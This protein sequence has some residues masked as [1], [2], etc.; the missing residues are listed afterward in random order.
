M[1]PESYEKIVADF[2]RKD[3]N[4]SILQAYYKGQKHLYASQICV[5]NIS[6]DLGPKEFGLEKEVK[7][8]M[9]VAH[10]KGTV[11][12]PVGGTYHFVGIADDLMFVRFD[13]KTVHNSSLRFHSG[14]DKDL[15]H[16]VGMHAYGKG[17]DKKKWRLYK[18][19][20]MR[21]VG[22]KSYPIEILIGEQP[23]GVCYFV[24]LI[25]KEGASYKIEPSFNMPIL[26]VFR[27]ADV[28]HAEGEL[29]PIQEGGPI[30][31][32]QKPAPKSALDLLKERQ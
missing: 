2:I 25:E 20:P 4:E 19:E 24:L 29:P 13:G 7:P 26:P 6:A 23:G 17:D 15:A 9:W 5:P 14:E 18:G 10:Y 30:W 16:S 22:G 11:T 27:I 8:R 3:W 28:P 32:A 21:V 1:T 12:P 31:K